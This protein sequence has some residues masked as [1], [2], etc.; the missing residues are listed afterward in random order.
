MRPSLG[1]EDIFSTVRPLLSDI[2]DMPPQNIT[3]DALLVD[4]LGMDSMGAVETISALSQIYGIEI[5]REELASVR[6]VQDVVDT[7]TNLL[8]RK[9]P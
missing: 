2:L 5:R 3:P 9:R 8:R 6:T 1:R 4:D 7:V